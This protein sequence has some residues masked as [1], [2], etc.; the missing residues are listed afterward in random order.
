MLETT[1]EHD[2]H[3]PSSLQWIG[4][5]L[6]QGKLEPQLTPTEEWLLDPLIRYAHAAG[7]HEAGDY[8]SALKKRAIEKLALAA[9]A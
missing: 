7:L 5:R 3:I 8:F 2:D 4:L 1:H 9:K 6:R